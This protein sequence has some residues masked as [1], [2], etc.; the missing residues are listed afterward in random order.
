MRL[1]TC[2]PRRFVSISPSSLSVIELLMGFLNRHANNFTS[3]FKGSRQSFDN[4][5]SPDEVPREEF[6]N[7]PKSLWR[8]PIACPP[9]KV[10]VIQPEVLAWF[11]PQP[12]FKLTCA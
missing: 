6:L 2:P 11:H 8:V 9:D 10:C 4:C 1:K 3:N 5:S 7:P 12:V